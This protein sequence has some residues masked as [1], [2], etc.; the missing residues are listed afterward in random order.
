[1]NALCRVHLGFPVGGGGKLIEC[2]VHLCGGGGHRSE[3]GR[4]L[5]G[6]VQVLLQSAWR[7]SQMPTGGTRR[8]DDAGHNTTTHIAKW[9]REGSSAARLIDCC[10]GGVRLVSR[11]LAHVRPKDLQKA[12]TSAFK[13]MPGKA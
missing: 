4:G 10:S 3:A 9:K 13:Y 8:R 5:R 1:M 7:M 2:E 11:L 6:A 12:H